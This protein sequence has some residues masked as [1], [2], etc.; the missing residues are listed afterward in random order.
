MDADA[1]V[2]VNDGSEDARVALDLGRKRLCSSV[3]AGLLQADEIPNSLAASQTQVSCVSSSESSGPADCVSSSA[4]AATSKDDLPPP[5]IDVLPPEL[6]ARALRFAF[7]GPRFFI[8]DP[9]VRRSVVCSVYRF[10]G[11][12][13]TQ[14][15]ES[16]SYLVVDHT[17][18]VE[19]VELA[20]SRSGC[21]PLTIELDCRVQGYRSAEFLGWA[22]P[23]VSPLFAR[24]KE[25]TVKALH[26]QTCVDVMGLLNTYSFPVL[27]DLRLDLALPMLPFSPSVPGVAVPFIANGQVPT[28]TRVSFMHGFPAWPW[29]EA[30]SSLTVVRL[31]RM[32][33]LVI[34]RLVLLHDFFRA[35]PN[36]VFLAVHY[37][38]A[39]PPLTS[40]HIPSYSAAAISLPHLKRLDV[41]LNIRRA[42]YVLAPIRAPKL[43]VLSLA[44]TDDKVLDDF[45]R[46]VGHLLLSVSILRLAVNFTSYVPVEVL[47]HAMPSL[48]HLDARPSSSTFV[49]CFHRAALF[50]SIMSTALR[51]AVLNVCPFPLVEDVLRFR[52][53]SNFHQDLSLVVPAFDHL[54]PVV[55]LVVCRLSGGKVDTDTTL[56]YV[57]WMDSSPYP[58][59]V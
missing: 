51:Y 49:D 54:Y 56:D 32:N 24:C 53:W 1:F 52:H 33:H 3:S 2:D 20:V 28:L 23:L 21:V 34:P 59:I 27:R 7:L 42:V 29:G 41:S 16:W 55:G 39:V 15:P 36:L 31:A 8:R 26:S 6:L 14:D 19:D 11:E 35:C 58:Y 5:P 38:D 22:F 46:H 25:L 37:V 10:W 30:G 57:D 45:V 50:G 43:G 47:L 9:S 17:T 44:I 48:S 12:V 40:G 13:I 4:E 18:R